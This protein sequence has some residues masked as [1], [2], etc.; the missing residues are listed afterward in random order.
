MRGHPPPVDRSV[1]FLH[2]PKAAGTTLHD[3]LERQ[4]AREEIFNIVGPRDVREKALGSLPESERRRLR[5]VKGHMHFGVHE[6]LPNPSTYITVLRHPVERVISHYYYVRRTPRHYLYETVVGD[7]LSL[8][9]YVF[10][11][12]SLELN[13]GQ[14]RTIYGAKHVDVPYGACT[15]EMLTAA[16]ANLREY[17]SVVGLAERFDETL[18]LMQQQLGWRRSPVYVRKNVTKSRRAR[19]DVPASVIRRIEADNALDLE[20]YEEESKYFMGAV[21]RL[22]SEQPTLL[23]RFRARRR[24]YARVARPL[25]RARATVAAA[26]STIVPPPNEG[27]AHA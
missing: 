7:D 14:V 4:Y 21:A 18:L 10:D 25:H 22:L 13:N 17:F 27:S 6:Y 24:F 11:Q 8:E 26:L 16:R 5:L 19:A 12:V 2:I 1:I 20:L 9:Q 23:N 15:P 3:I